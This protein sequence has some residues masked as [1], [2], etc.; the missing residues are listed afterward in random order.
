MISLNTTNDLIK[1]TDWKTM[2]NYARLTQQDLVWKR[3]N[4]NGE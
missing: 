4:Q 1:S 3:R 2:D